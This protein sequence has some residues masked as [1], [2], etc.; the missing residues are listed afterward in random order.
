MSKKICKL[1]KDKIQKS[2]PK[3]YKSL[4]KDP[5]YFCKSCGHVAVKSSHLCKPEK[6]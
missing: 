6:L 3:K 5:K 1:V 4:V 2:D